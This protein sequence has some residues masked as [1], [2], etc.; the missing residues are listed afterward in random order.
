[1][2]YCITNSL[3]PPPHKPT[4]GWAGIIPMDPYV[5][6]GVEVVAEEM[7]ADGIMRTVRT[8]RHFPAVADFADL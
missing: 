6:V 7:A 4:A 2:Y 5:G 8:N 1:M 3:T